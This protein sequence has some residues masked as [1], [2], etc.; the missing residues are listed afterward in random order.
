MSLR[1]AKNIDP[2]KVKG[3]KLMKKPAPLYRKIKKYRLMNQIDSKEFE[4]LDTVEEPIPK[5]LKKPKDTETSET[6][7]TPKI[8]EKSEKVKKI[9]KAPKIP[10]ASKSPEHS[11]SSKIESDEETVEVKKVKTENRERKDNVDLRESCDYII[12]ET[13]HLEYPHRKEILNMILE[14][15]YGDSVSEAND[16]SR[17]PMSMLSVDLINQIK[18]FVAVKLKA[19][20]ITDRFDQLYVSKD[21]DDK[22]KNSEKPEKLEKPGKKEKT[23]KS[24][25]SDK[26]IKKK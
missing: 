4:K 6:R 20:D 1:I 5:S 8:S 26:S 17:I 22:S 18:N 21:E 2:S 25:K 13:D 19:I 23:D 15:G 12:R 11:K 9:E 24:K 3:V 10:K 7:E 16:G 14:Q